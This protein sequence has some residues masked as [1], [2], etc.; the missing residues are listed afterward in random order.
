MDETYFRN[1]VARIICKSPKNE[2][3]W[4]MGRLFHGNEINLGKRIK[5]IIEPFKKLERT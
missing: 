1:M 5:M 3:K 2:R 4:L